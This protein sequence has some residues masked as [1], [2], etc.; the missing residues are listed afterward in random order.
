VTRIDGSDAKLIVAS[1]GGS[2]LV[3]VPSGDA[4]IVHQTIAALLEL[5]YVGGIFVDDKYCPTAKECAGT[6]P[7]SAVGLVGASKV[8]RPAI[9]IAFRHFYQKA[10]DLQSG[11]QIS[12]T[13]LQE[14]QGMH[15]GFGRDQTLNN[16]AAWGPDFKSGFVDEA[17]VGNMDLTP[18]IASILGIEMPSVG[19]LKG[20]VMR[21]AMV[22][23]STAV[24][25]GLKT[26]TSEATADGARTVME[27]EEMSGVRYYDRACVATKD[28]AKSCW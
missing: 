17:P 7:L 22:G 14:G 19:S 15:G 6:L 18:T 4:A 28:G 11:V 5:D 24:G 27:Y 8:P 10:G 13:T 25:S 9:A 23:Q 3:Y 16:M 21:E 12:D 1:N 2:D 26:M 20:R